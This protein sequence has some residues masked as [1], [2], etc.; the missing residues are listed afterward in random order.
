M[1]ADM[2][3]KV[4]LGEKHVVWN[5]GLAMECVRCGGKYDVGKDIGATKVPIWLFQGI[6]WGFAAEH[7]ECEEKE[8]TNHQD[9]SVEP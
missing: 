6:C 3:R 2:I 9:S 7:A 4:G 5:G 8:S 1:D